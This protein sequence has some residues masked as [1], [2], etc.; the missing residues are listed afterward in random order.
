MV[1]PFGH[2]TTKRISLVSSFIQVATSKGDV[3]VIPTE[4][5][6]ALQ[7]YNDGDYEISHCAGEFIQN[8]DR[9]INHNLAYKTNNL[10]Y[11]TNEIMKR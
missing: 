6:S 5:S 10:A 9:I 1:N 11:E 3:A 7:L 2:L 8:I 4:G